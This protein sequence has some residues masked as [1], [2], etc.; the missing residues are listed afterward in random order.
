MLLLVAL[1]LTG[2]NSV[3]AQWIGHGP[4]CGYY[5]VDAGDTSSNNYS[6]NTWYCKQKYGREALMT[7]AAAGAGSSFGT[8]CFEGFGVGCTNGKCKVWCG[9]EAPPTESCPSRMQ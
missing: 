4:V 7:S 2:V 5:C 8:T 1:A 6:Y 9:S 3:F